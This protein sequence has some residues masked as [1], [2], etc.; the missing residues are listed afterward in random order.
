VRLELDAFSGVPNPHWDLPAAESRR[1][2]AKIESLPEVQAPV[3]VPDLGFRGFLLHKDG[4]LI[5][6]YGG[7]VIRQAQGR[8]TTYRDTAGIEG[9]LAADARTRGYSDVLPASQPPR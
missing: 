7:Y 8:S 3:H 6:V 2:T 9:Q 4:E 1:I 5:R